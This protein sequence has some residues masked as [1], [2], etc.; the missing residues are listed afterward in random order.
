MDLR[1]MRPDVYGEGGACRHAGS[2]D[3]HGERIRGTREPQTQQLG[4]VGVQRGHAGSHEEA[5]YEQPPV[6]H[7]EAAGER[8]QRGDYERHQEHLAQTYAVGQDAAGDAQ[9][10]A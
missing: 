1:K 7:H 6:V 2:V 9:Q 10:H 3:A 8:P 5:G 4:R